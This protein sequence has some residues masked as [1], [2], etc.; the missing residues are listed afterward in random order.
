M[1][2]FSDIDHK[3]ALISNTFANLTGSTIRGYEYAQM[4]C[5]ED[6]MWDN[7][8]DMPLFL[9]LDSEVIS[10]SWTKF[11]DLAV[12]IG[13]SLPF[14]LCGYTVRWLSEGIQELDSSLGKKIVSATLAE[15]KTGLWT[16]LLLELDSGQVLEIYNALDETGIALR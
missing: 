14:S 6:E 5:D 15:G 9:I 13:R 11:D 7:W 4:W 16:R 12:E 3:S 10:I 2:Y 8:M 1:K